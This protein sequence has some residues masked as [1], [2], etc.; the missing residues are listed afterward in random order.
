MKVNIILMSDYILSSKFYQKDKMDFFAF[1]VINII[2]E[3]K[4]DKDLSFKEILNDLYI[5]SEMM[6]LFNNAYYLLLDEGLLIGKDQSF[7][8]L[9]K[10][11]V[12]LTDFG[13]ECLKE[14]VVP[15][16]LYSLENNFIYDLINK[17]ICAE[18]KFS[19]ETKNVIVIDKT[20]DENKISLLLNENKR[21][22]F[23]SIDEGVVIKS[24]LLEANPL[25]VEATLIKKNNMYVLE[26]VKKDKELLELINKNFIFMNVNYLEKINY[27]EENAQILTK[28]IVFDIVIGNE[29]ILK[30]NSEYY[31]I[32]DDNK[33]LN[34]EDNIL[35]ISKELFNDYFTK[36]N[37]D[38]FA[39]ID[40]DF[41]LFNYL[42]E[43]LEDDY[44]MPLLISKK[45]RSFDFKKIL[46]DKI[47]MFSSKDVVNK[48]I[49]KL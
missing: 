35:Y 8:T 7:E 9:R 38:F 36:H 47:S 17:R 3:E 24:K 23:P 5:S 16:Y 34:V 19:N 27:K 15:S 1:L 20:L 11:E 13:R 39:L 28:N 42:E 2:A 18:N 30:L 46:K 45:V 21:K 10:D 43:T 44:Q 12:R 26:G 49:E 31:L 48:I 33:A 32:I 41:V 25:L 14:N 4:I 40:G 22:M 29:E 37:A 6:Y